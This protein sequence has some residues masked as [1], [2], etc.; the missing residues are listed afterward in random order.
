MNE[1]V[2]NILIA[3]FS[4]LLAFIGQ[5]YYFEKQYEIQELDIHT[6]FTTDY[7]AKPNFPNSNIEFKING[8]EKDKVG[9]LTISILNYS[10]KNYLDIPVNIKITPKKMSDFNILAYSAVGEKEMTDLVSEIKPISIDKRSY[11]FSYKVRSINREYKNNYGMQLKVIFEGDTEPQIDVI[12]KGVGTR[13][14]DSNNSPYQQELEW[15]AEWM[16]IGVFLILIVLTFVFVWLILSPI[17]ARLTKKWDRKNNQKYAKE[18]FDS[19]KIDNL[20]QGSTDQELS[21]FV[22][23]MLYKRQLFLWNKKTSIGKWSLGYIQPELS[24]FTIEL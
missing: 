9:L 20:K 14:Y 21:S 15:K 23:N 2:K 6:Q 4:F 24:D 16:A 22:A 11:N 5:Y 13:K 3:L 10:S 18:I 7:I 8:I 19:I 17:I 12:G 1:L